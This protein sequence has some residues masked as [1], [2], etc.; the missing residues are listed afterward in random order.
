MTQHSRL[1][2]PQLNS[3]LETRLKLSQS[4]APKLFTHLNSVKK[5]DKQSRWQDW[6][7]PANP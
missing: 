2:T 3:D 6:P 4:C 1:K 7:K 5:I